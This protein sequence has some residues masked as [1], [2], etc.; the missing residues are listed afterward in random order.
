M[1][2]PYSASPQPNGR[3]VGCNVITTL[4]GSAPITS[5]TRNSHY[6]HSAPIRIPPAFHIFHS[7]FCPHQASDSPTFPFL[8]PSISSS[9]SFILFSSWIIF[10][11]LSF[12]TP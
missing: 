5:I 11:Y 6:A 7:I 8:F 2:F 1:H 9:R 10:V 12:S 4:I 3:L